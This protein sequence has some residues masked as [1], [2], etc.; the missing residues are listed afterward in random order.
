MKFANGAHD[1]PA[2]LALPLLGGVVQAQRLVVPPQVVMG[3]PS[4][5]H[6]CRL[7]WKLRNRRISQRTLAELAGLYPSHVSDYFSVHAHKRELPAKHVGAVCA[8]LGNT[9]IV[10]W[11]AQASSVTLMEELQAA[12]SALG[13]TF[14]KAA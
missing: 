7:A 5:R 3:L 12:R 1:G 13:R 2:Q 11:L 14:A 8:V 6:A 4:Y 9:V 10:Q